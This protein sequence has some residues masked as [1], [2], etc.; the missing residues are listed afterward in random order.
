MKSNNKS[1]NFVSLFKYLMLIPAVLA[2]VAIVIGAIFHFNLDYDFQKVSNFTVKFNTTV[3]EEEYDALE[4]SLCSIV[5]DNG[6]DDYRIERIGDGAQNGLIVKV[7]NNDGELDGK[8]AELK[9]V[10]EDTLLSETESV[11]SSVV[12]STTDLTYSLP[13]NISRMFW[14]AMLALA[15]VVVFVIGYNWIRYNLMAGLSLATS[16]ALEVAMLVSC[17][18]VFR[19]PVNYNFV[20]PFVVMVVTT[21]INSVLM[22]NSIKNNLNNESYNKYTN[23]QRVM[24]ATKETYKG[25]AIYMAMILVAVLGIMFFGGASMIYLGLATIVGLLVSAFVSIMVNGSLWSFW[26]RRDKDKVLTH[27]LN[28]E[29]KRLEAKNN[30]NKQQ[31][32]KIV[33]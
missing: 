13:R 19:I 27:R 4:N 24:S 8:L 9:V 14:F 28:V 15:C 22:N 26:Y 25:I 12:V 5:K 23:S 31:D 6:F 16:I 10:V 20:L 2:L 11:E 1:C 3:T 7:P 29:K 18:I 33:V 30:K 32:E 21:I 17:L